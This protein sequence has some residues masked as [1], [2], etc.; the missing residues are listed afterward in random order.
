M[1]IRWV[2]FLVVSTTLIAPLHAEVVSE[3]SHELDA[4][5]DHLQ[6]SGARVHRNGSYRVTIM[7]AGN[8]EVQDEIPASYSLN[9][10][11]TP[12][13][14]ETLDA[15]LVLPQVE[16]LYVGSEF[17]RTA[18][19]WDALTQLGE[20]KHLYLID[21]LCDADFPR[22][23]QFENL[24]VLSLRLGGFAPDQMWY[25]ETLS[26]L[27]TLSLTVDR[28]LFRNYLSGLPEIPNLNHLEVTILNDS[29]ISFQG[30]EHLRSLKS[31]EIN[32]KN[33]PASELRSIGQLPNLQ[34]LQLAH[35][36]FEP[37]DLSLLHELNH[38]EHMVLY[39]C[40]LPDI[41]GADLARLHELQRFDATRT[42]LT[43]DAIRR[44]AMLPK[45]THLSIRNAPITDGCLRAIAASPHLQSVRLHAT[46]VSPEGAQWLQEA[47]PDLSF[48]YG[49]TR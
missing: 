35:V 8:E 11:E 27:E 1:L 23:A 30:V 47:R 29:P 24:D 28:K 19:A 18:E 40:D 26:Q 41:D 44:L 36:R 25:L 9:L 43:D 3:D 21:D 34:R 48:S 2:F 32:A 22:L 13:T 42:R 10:M 17:E 45:L 38:L 15:I 14:P 46:S 49:E 4:A 5:I 39:S 7:V 6:Q 31:L 37:E 12:S 33:Q 16:S 20:L